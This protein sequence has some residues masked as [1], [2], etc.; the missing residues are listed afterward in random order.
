MLPFLQKR[1][2]VSIIKGTLNKKGIKFNE[3]KTPSIEID[4]RSKSVKNKDIADKVRA[5]ASKKKE[6]T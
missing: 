2:I 1:R 4:H 3:P 5:K 6:S